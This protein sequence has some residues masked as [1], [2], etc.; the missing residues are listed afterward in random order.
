MPSKAATL[1]VAVKPG[2]K[3]P[4]IA[5]ENGRFVLRVRERAVD[6]AA[7][8]ACLRALGEALALPRS[9]IVLV[10]GATSR[11]KIFSIEHLDDAQIEAR[12]VAA[13]GGS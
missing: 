13:A 6:G 2:S 1:H 7:N 8:D 9:A 5:Y 11:L 3:R 10:R 12:L 4:G